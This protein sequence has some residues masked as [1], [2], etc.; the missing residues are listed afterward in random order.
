MKNDDF[1]Y[2]PDLPLQ[3]PSF[4]SRPTDL[5]F[6]ARWFALN[7]LMLSE[8]MMLLILA[9]A[10]WAFVYPPLEVS[11]TFAIGWIAQVYGANLALMFMF[12]SPAEL[13]FACMHGYLCHFY[14]RVHINLDLDLVILI[15]AL[16]RHPMPL[17]RF[18]C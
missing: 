11:K 10:M 9:I 1:N 13:Q 4:F 7:W 3:D 16:L 12:S 15:L 5:G 14:C 18:R 6:L 8:R 17:R 2:H